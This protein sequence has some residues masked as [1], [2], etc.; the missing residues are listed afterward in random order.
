[1]ESEPSDSDSKRT[2][3]TKAGICCT[4]FSFTATPESKPPILKELVFNNQEDS[5][6]SPEILVSA[7]STLREMKER[8]RVNAFGMKQN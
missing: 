7:E 5:P 8:D 3:D 6:S 4:V 1:M 2:P